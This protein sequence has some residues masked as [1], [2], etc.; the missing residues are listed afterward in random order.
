MDD[1]IS[2]VPHNST[3]AK[4]AD[5]ESHG[6]DFHSTHMDEDDSRVANDYRLGEY[7]SDVGSDP[8]DNEVD[9]QDADADV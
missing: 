3:K 6:Y 5:M 4:D 7:K 8:E 1:D 2:F 9:I